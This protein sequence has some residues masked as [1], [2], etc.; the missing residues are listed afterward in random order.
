MK[1]VKGSAMVHFVKAIRSNKSGV[2]NKYFL[3]E[4]WDIISKPILPALWYSYE[5]Y[6]RCFTAVFEI[7]AHKDYEKVKE[8]AR[9]Y[10]D[11]IMTDIY[12]HTI[13]KDDPLYHIKNAPVYIQTFYDFGHAEVKV[14]GPKKVVLHLSDYDPDFAPFY[15]FHL[16]WFQR[17]VELCGARNANCEFLEMSWVTKRNTT[18]YLVTWE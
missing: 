10:A 8:W 16:G 14:E 6:K 4:D 5:T 9:L 3:K 7:A 13:K 18:T 1:K 12:K 17:V 15:F 2:Y 11:L